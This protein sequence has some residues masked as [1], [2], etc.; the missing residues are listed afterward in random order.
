MHHG[1]N[2]GLGYL[3]SGWSIQVDY[4]AAINYPFKG[5]ELTPD[6]VIHRFGSVD[7]RCKV[8]KRVNGRKGRR[9]RRG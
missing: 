8:V 2:N 9:G 7:W 3:G 5:G 6:T 1:I 4:W